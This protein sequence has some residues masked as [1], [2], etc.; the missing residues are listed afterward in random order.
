MGIEIHESPRYSA[1][2]QAVV[3]AGTVMTIEPGIYLP[4]RFGVRIEDTVLVKENGIEIP[5]CTSKQLI[6]L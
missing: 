6:I 2:E 3:E 1:A 4:G 5:G